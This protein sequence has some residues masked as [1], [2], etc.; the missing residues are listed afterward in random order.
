M[1]WKGANSS[2]ICH[3]QSTLERPLILSVLRR[4]VRGRGIAAPEIV[5]QASELLPSRFPPEHESV[6][7]KIQVRNEAHKP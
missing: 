4:V 7:E 5:D 6:P 3:G 1:K 2:Q